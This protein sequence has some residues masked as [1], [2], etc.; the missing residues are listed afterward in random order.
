MGRISNEAKKLQDEW[1]KWYLLPDGKDTGGRTIRRIKRY[2]RV[3]EQGSIRTLWERYPI[4]HYRGMSTTEVESLLRRLNATKE[5]QRKLAA[6]R[7]NFDHAY[8]NQISVA[9]F[10][11]HLGKRIKVDGYKKNVIQMLNTYVFKFFIIDKK[12]PDPSLWHQKEDEWGDFLL[13]SG[14]GGKTI[15][16][17]IATANRFNNFLVR[18]VYPEMATPRRLEPIGKVLLDE[19]GEE[20]GKFI[21][22]EIYEKILEDAEKK[23]PDV[24]PNI[25]LCYAFGFRIGETLGLTKDKFLKSH[26]LVDEQGNRVIIAK[27]GTK[28]V[29]RRKA[30]TFERK[31]PYWNMT[32]REAWALVQQLKPMHPKTLINRVNDLLRPFGHKS[33]DFR[34][35]FITNAFRKVHWKDIMRAAGHRDVRTTMKYDLDDRGLSEEKADLD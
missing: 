5:A 3:R 27:D 24:L 20:P 28:T 14:L 13:A 30:K 7:Y 6:E 2:R 31:V 26:I 32:A 10:E 23:A 16:M 34:R 35:T 8:V 15:R 29:S 17:V 11:K 4:K 12:L 19:L 18:S 22:P 1:S 9:K 25:K 21:T 33:H